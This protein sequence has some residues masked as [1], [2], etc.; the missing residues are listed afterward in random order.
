M[1]YVGLT[2]SRNCAVRLNAP[3]KTEFQGVVLHKWTDTVSFEGRVAFL[4]GVC[5]CPNHTLFR[6]KCVVGGDPGKPTFRFRLDL[7]FYDI[8]V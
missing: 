4:F 6:L 3:P 8:H 2:I 5:V 7:D 1:P